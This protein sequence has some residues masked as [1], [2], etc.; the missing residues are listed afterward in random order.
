MQNFCVTRWN[1][2]DLKAQAF[3]DL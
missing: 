2:S 3:S 1:G